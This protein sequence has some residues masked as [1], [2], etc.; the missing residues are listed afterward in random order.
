MNALMHVVDHA[1]KIYKADCLGWEDVIN[2]ACELLTLRDL[3]RFAALCNNAHDTVGGEYHLYE[4]WQ[5]SFLGCPTYIR[6]RSGVEA[7]KED[8]G[9]NKENWGGGNKSNG[10]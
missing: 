7:C 5:L 10:G 2:G 8:E 1:N 6:I 9:G 4:E 3:E